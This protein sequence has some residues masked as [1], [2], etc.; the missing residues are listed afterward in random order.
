MLQGRPDLRNHVA[1]LHHSADWVNWYLEGRPSGLGWRAF[2]QDADEYASSRWSCSNAAQPKSP[3]QRQAVC[4]SM[5]RLLGAPYDWGA[6]EADAAEALRLPEA[7][8]KWGDSTVMPGHVVCSSSAAWAYR[9]NGLAAPELGGG[10]FTE[11]ADWDAF[12]TEA[13][14]ESRPEGIIPGL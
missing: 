9:V 2:R 3:A 6:I 5:L 10:R 14:W 7:W 13:P 4:A 1:M 12:I 8:R 11:P